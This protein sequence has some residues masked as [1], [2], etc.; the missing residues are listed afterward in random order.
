MLNQ[1]GM[2]IKGASPLEAAS[3]IVT[4][5]SGATCPVSGTILVA[6]TNR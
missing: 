1:L 5:A 4:L 6:D 2:D 3:L